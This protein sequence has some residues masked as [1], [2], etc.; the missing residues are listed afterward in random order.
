ME[1]IDLLIKIANGE[2]PKRFKLFLGNN[3]FEYELSDNGNYYNIQTEEEFT[4]SINLT[5]CLNNKVEMIKEEMC[6]K[7]HK[8]PAEHNQTYCEFCL[9]I[10]KE[11]KK[12]PD[13]LNIELN[14][15]SVDENKVNCYRATNLEC[16]LAIKINEII[17]KLNEVSK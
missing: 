1:L 4:E 7:C 16:E 15:T 6:H 13:K 12:I 9:G 5:F 11:E 17:E 3:V 2:K 10:S 8:Y 14:L